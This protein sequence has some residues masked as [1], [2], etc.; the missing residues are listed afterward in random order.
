M[1]SITRLSHKELA[2]LHWVA[3]GKTSFE[4]GQILS[5]SESG[6]NYHIRNACLKLNANTRLQAIMK[7]TNADEQLTGYLVT[8]ETPRRNSSAWLSG[9]SRGLAVTK[10]SV[11]AC[12][13]NQKRAFSRK[14]RSGA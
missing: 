8:A 5:L 10:A 14:I 7:L 2:C 6:V 13:D 9:K 12:S 1:F 4:I 3:Q 11:R